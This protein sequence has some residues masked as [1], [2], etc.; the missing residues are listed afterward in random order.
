MIKAIDVHVHPGTKEDLIDSGGKYLAAAMSYFGKEVK[1]ITVEELAEKYRSQD[2]FGVL[3]AWDAETNTGLPPVTNDYIAS[4]VK[5]YPD[6]FIGFA[7]VDPW[8]G[9]VAIQELERAAKELGLRG[10]KF[11]QA[12]QGFFPNDKQFYPLWEKCVELDLPVQFHVGN[13]G[14]GAGVPGGCGIHLKYVRP[15]PYI[16]DLAADFP[17]LTIICLHPAWPWQEE[18]LA[19]AMHKGNVYLDLSGWSP[20]YFPQ[21]LVTYAN[22]FLK[23]KVMFG[24]DHPYISPERWLQD[25][26]KAGFKPELKDKILLENAKRALKLQF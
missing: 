17:E 12:A 6:T 10:A 4:I 14:Y 18:M 11:Q 7:S 3:V 15:V 9:K 26:D 8:K 2:I 21:S 19:V 25:F 20:K 16:D 1:T 22:T 24:S 5:K 13:T 23:D